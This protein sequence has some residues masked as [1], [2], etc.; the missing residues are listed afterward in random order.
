MT[1]SVANGVTVHG[2]L[3][4]ASTVPPTAPTSVI[5]AAML[6]K[7]PI[8][9]LQEF[10]AQRGM[11]TPTYD[12]IANE[13]NLGAAHEP[14]FVYRVVVGEI[15]ATGKGSSKKKAKHCAAQEALK[16]VASAAGQDMSQ[17]GDRP[18]AVQPT[19]AQPGLAQSS[20]V[21]PN[22]AACACCNCHRANKANSSSR[23]GKEIVDT[24]GTVVVKVEDES[25][26]TEGH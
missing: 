21:Q 12:L 20:P 17:A 8:S 22:P 5:S 10:C 11:M 14:L 6:T 23:K 2:I 15:V 26:E 16:V 9:V 3:N 7:S 24:D 13:G 19:P 18:I 1:Q 25:D 4:G